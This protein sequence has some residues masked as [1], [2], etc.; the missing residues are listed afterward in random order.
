MAAEGVFKVQTDLLLFRQSHI[1]SHSSGK[2]ERER[3]RILS[4]LTVGTIKG[5]PGFDL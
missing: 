2:M 1:K 4:K 3:R 5:N